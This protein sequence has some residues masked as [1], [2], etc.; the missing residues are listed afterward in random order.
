MQV[1][2]LKHDP[3]PPYAIPVAGFK[4]RKAAQVSAFFALKEDGIIDKL[5]LIKLIYFSER[6]FLSENH[7]P[8]LWDEFYSLFNGPICSGTL[9]GI[10]G[11]IH[12]DIWSEFVARNG[13]QVVALKKFGRSDFDE[14]SNAEWAAI[15]YIW[16]ELGSK[17]T[18]QLRNYS[19]SHCPEYTQVPEGERLPISYRDILE[20]FG[21]QTADSVER[22][23][24]SA[25]RAES[26]LAA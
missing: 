26:A 21:D 11:V 2:I 5:K 17:T 8:I 4:S 15:E 7:I 9:N 18:S 25:R 10:N 19:H 13:N 22:E 16:K 6:K 1:G 3:I 23:I 12:V 24:N 14:I 20:A